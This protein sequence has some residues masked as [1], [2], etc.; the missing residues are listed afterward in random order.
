MKTVECL[1]EECGSLFPKPK[2]EYTRSEK[3]GK[4][5]FCSLSCTGLYNGRMKRAKEV[6]KVCP[7][8]GEEFVS[9]TKK[10]A[11]TFCSR[12]CASAGSMSDERREAQRQGGLEKQG[13][14]SPAASMKVREDWKYILL[15]ESLSGRSHEFEFPL[16]GAVFD[17]A[18][19]D[20]RILVE[21]DGPD[22]LLEKQQ[23]RDREKEKIAEENRFL[24]VR[25]VVKR[26]EVISPETIDGL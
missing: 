25:R 13:N 26:A 6:L 21:F 18:L 2:G 4:K 22:H 9:T 14:L 1:C 15:K 11:A 20:R 19:F 12:S 16:D 7:H 10:K 17:L 23:E 5:H 24:V 3:L 8:C